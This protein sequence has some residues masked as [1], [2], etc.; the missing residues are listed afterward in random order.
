MRT[1]FIIYIGKVPDGEAHI[2]HQSRYSTAKCMQRNGVNYSLFTGV[3]I[4][5]FIN[6]FI[7]FFFGMN[8]L[9]FRTM[10]SFN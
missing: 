5:L 8:Y 10:N 1:E 2:A 4:H 7:Q 6:S 3:A 9:Y